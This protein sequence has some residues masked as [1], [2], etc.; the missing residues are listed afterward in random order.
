MRLPPLSGY[1]Q[2]RELTEARKSSE[3]L[4]QGASVVQQQAVLDLDRAFKNWWSNPSHFG[5]PTWRKAGQ[6]EGFGVR[7]S[8]VRRLNRK[9]GEVLIPKAGWVRFRVTRQFA[10]VADCKSARVT[11]DRTGRWHVSF[12]APQPSVPKVATGAIV[13]IDLGVAHTVT[14]SD[15]YHASP[16]RLTAAEQCRKRLLQRKFAR[17]QKG[18]NRRACTKHAIA[19]LAATETARRKDWRE[20]TTTRLVREYDGIAVENLQVRNMV[21]SAS[22]TV[23]NPGT[24]VVQK[25]GLN[26]AISAQGLAEFRKRLEDKAAAATTWTVVKAV[27]PVN[28]SRRCNVCGHIAEGN[29][30]SQTVFVCVKC[31]HRAN[32]DV[33]A[34]KNIRD[35]A[36]FGEV[37][38][39]GLAVTGRGG[40][41]MS[42]ACEAS[43]IVAGQPATETRHLQH[44]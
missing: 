5:R 32:A 13:G 26:R 11:M 37:L 20:K 10:D 40:T 4:R 30:Q 21:R 9:W 7:D 39:A 42:R 44:V 15:G 23:E 14:T 31:G 33:N 3:W 36:D 19:K 35:L 41:G 2:N 22:G 17:Q 6:H 16:G 12:V 29:R 8:K 43:T 18:S 34:G 27:N 24:N 1:D 28:T 38:A 25:R